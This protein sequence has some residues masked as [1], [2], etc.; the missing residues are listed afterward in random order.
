LVVLQVSVS[1]SNWEEAAVEL[2]SAAYVTAVNVRKAR[3]L[4]RFLHKLEQVPSVVVVS[5]ECDASALALLATATFGHVSDDVS[6]SVTAD[7]VLWLGLTWSLPHAIGAV[8]AKGLLFGGTLDAA[9]LRDSGLAHRGDPTAVSL[10]SPHDALLV[11]SL[12]HAA[13]STAMQAESYDAQL[14]ELL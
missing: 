12:G 3:G 2:R 13:R 11:R 8:A 1:V 14:R 7:V 6:V 4:A 10:D 5:G 9:A